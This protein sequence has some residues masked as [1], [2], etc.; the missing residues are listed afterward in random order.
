MKV[1]YFYYDKEVSYNEIKEH[2]EHAKNEAKNY[3][4]VY[5]YKVSNIEVLSVTLVLGELS[6]L[7]CGTI[8]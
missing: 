1:E 4:E 3:F 2:I 6:I 7:V 5:E 8:D